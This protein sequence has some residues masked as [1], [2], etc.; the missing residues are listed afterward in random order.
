M[1]RAGLPFYFAHTER[2]VEN[3][4]RQHRWKVDVFVPARQIVS[5]LQTIRSPLGNR[6]FEAIHAG[7]I[8]AETALAD[9]RL[10]RAARGHFSG[11]LGH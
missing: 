9:N 6:L 11:H 10:W 2:V 8:L 3:S 4:P 5:F 1:A 7:R